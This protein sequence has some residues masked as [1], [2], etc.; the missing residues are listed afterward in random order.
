MGQLLS[1]GAT[2]IGEDKRMNSADIE[3]AREVSD[4]KVH[5]TYLVTL[6]SALALQL[7]RDW[8]EAK[9]EVFTVR[10]TIMVV[11]WPMKFKQGCVGD[12]NQLE[13]VEGSRVPVRIL[14]TALDSKEVKTYELSES[15]GG[16]IGIELRSDL[17]LSRQEVNNGR[18]EATSEAD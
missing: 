9:Q 3:R 6:K 15:L 16:P 10:S 13:P 8:K 11:E 12:L 17:V 5:K 14:E 1:H 4:G 18:K 2:R 7:K